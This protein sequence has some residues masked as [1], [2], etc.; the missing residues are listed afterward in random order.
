M[1]RIFR[2][3]YVQIIRYEIGIFKY[4]KQGQVK[5]Y[6][7]YEKKFSD[8]SRG[9]TVEEPGKKIVE[10]DGDEQ[11][12]EISPLSPGVE[13]ETGDHQEGVMSL[14]FQQKEE[15]QE[16]RQEEKQKNQ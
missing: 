8:F 10:Q 14:F 16:N 3:R 1:D 2:E 7:R 12:Q 6:C 11:Q 4:D 9:G 5:Y 13:K 15:E